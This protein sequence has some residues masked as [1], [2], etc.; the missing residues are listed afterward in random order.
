MLF[1]TS[2]EKRDAAERHWSD[3]SVYFHLAK[4]WNTWTPEMQTF[5]VRNKKRWT[6][7][8]S[9]PFLEIGAQL[10]TLGPEL[11]LLPQASQEEH[12]AAGANGSY[13]PMLD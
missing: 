12:W 1:H 3:S 4:Q 7:S 2:E 11:Q 10:H 5:S 9:L 6:S 8:G 13:Y